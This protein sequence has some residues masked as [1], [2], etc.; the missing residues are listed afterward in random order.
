MPPL[1]LSTTRPSDVTN[2]SLYWRQPSARNAAGP[3]PPIAAVVR[4]AASS[5]RRLSGSRLGG[6]PSG[7]C[8]DHVAKAKPRGP[9]LVST[10]KQFADH[11]F[12]KRRRRFERHLETVLAEFRYPRGQ[13]FI[14]ALQLQDDTGSKWDRCTAA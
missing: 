13:R 12:V 6:E 11:R 5:A 10:R 7:D 8:N 3:T 1:A 4:N 14:D 9:E 2:R